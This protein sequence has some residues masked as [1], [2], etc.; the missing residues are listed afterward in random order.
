MLN[1]FPAASIKMYAMMNLSI[2]LSCS[3]LRSLSEKLDKPKGDRNQLGHED[4]EHNLF[5]TVKRLHNSF[6]TKLIAS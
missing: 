6:N 4:Y 5:S 2:V 3:I 1:N